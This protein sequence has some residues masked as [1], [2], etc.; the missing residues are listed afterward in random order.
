MIIVRPDAYRQYPVGRNRFTLVLER[1]LSEYIQIEPPSRYETWDTL[2]VEPGRS[3]SDVLRSDIPQD[4][5]VL[6]VAQDGRL[7]TAPASEVGPRRTV[8]VLR[9]GT[10]SFAL[11]QLGKLFVALEKSDPEALG[12]VGAALGE[13]AVTAGGLVL[14]DPLTESIAKVTFSVPAWSRTDDTGSFRPA[15]VQSAPAGLRRLDL[16]ATG[17]SVT[18]QIAVKGWSVV[19]GPESDTAAGQEL[20]EKLSGL[21]HYP[22]VLT[23][24]EGKVTDTKATEAGSAIA[25]AALTHFFTAAPGRTEVTALEFGLNPAVPHLPFN[26]ESNAVGTGK[27]SASIH[28]VL[29]TLP[30]TEFEIVL[31][32]VTSSLTALGGTTPLAGAGTV[33][34][35]QSPRRRMNRVIAANC[36]CH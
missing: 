29:G 31:D 21:F 15:V 20:Y 27:A 4:S 1:W 32:C 9:A 7:L 13:A 23:V 26:C 17:S 18:G 30:L 22:L 25:A 8:A 35:E 5:D 6:V 2:P 3:L 11:D 19:R 36:G 28:L 16:S 12:A 14:E 10:G 33:L 34:A 24:E